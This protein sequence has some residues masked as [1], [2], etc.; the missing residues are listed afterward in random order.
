MIFLIMPYIEVKSRKQ[1]DSTLAKKIINK[2]D[3]I[4]VLTTGHITKQAKEAF[5]QADIAWAEYIEEKQFLESEA[6]EVE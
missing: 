1:I 6:Q 3:V 2:G 4:A 5:D